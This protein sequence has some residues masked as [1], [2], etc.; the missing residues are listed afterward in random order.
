M[1]LSVKDMSQDL[2]GKDQGRVRFQARIRSP[3]SS[4]TQVTAKF[5]LYR[6]NWYLIAS[7]MNHPQRDT[8][9]RHF[10]VLVGQHIYHNLKKILI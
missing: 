7:A 2:D 5:V 10:W 8:T 4:G 3:V 6:G 1:K 9:R